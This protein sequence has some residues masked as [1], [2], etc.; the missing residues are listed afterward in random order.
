MVMV[1]VWVQIVIVGEQYSVQIARLME[2]LIIVMIWMMIA[3]QI[4]MIVMVFAMVLLLKMNAVPVMAQ[5]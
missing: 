1:M 2:V 4:L 3:I 5:G